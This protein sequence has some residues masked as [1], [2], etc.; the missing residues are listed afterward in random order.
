MKQDVIERIYARLPR[1][2]ELIQKLVE[3]YN[4]PILALMDE[5][6]QHEGDEGNMDWT[7]DW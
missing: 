6:E 2:D 4:E 7:A 1:K 5:P 3:M